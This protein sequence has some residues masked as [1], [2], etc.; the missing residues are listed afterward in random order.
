MS[1]DKTFVNAMCISRQKNLL[2]KDKLARLLEC[3]DFDETIRML[4]EYG[5]GEGDAVSADYEHLLLSEQTKLYDFVRSYAPTDAIGA[6]LLAPKD[7]YNAEYLLRAAHVTLPELPLVAGTV[8]V[9]RVKKGIAGA[10]NLLPTWLVEP[11]K[12][13]EALFERGTA[14]GVAVSTVFT[15]AMYAYL[16]SV[17]KGRRVRGYVQWQID[18]KNVS[19]ALRSANRAEIESMY[20]E[21]G[22]VSLDSLVLLG[23]GERTAIDRRFAGT[24]YTEVV[25]LALDAKERK[26]PLVAYENAVDSAFLRSLYPERYS[27]EGDAPFLLYFGYKANDIANVRLILAGKLAGAD[28]E[29]IKA[30]LRVSYGE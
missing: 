17:C 18:A 8:S 14:T 22:K 30:R 19:I 3:A 28:K 7:F 2:G 4:G 24:D 20:I 21:G 13:A 6:F 1:V 29:N 11:V 23:K 5:F 27:C 9:D 16:L 10:Y 26:L 25:R 15:R 12:E